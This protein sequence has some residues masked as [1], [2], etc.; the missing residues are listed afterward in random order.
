MYMCVVRVRHVSPHG[1]DY[2]REHAVCVRTTLHEAVRACGAEPPVGATASLRMQRPMPEI[3]YTDDALPV[4][5]DPAAV[6][7][8]LVGL[9]GGLYVPAPYRATP[10]SLAAVDIPERLRR[11]G[12]HP[13]DVRGAMDGSVHTG[14]LEP[15]VRWTKLRQ[16]VAFRWPWH[17][18]RAVWTLQRRWRRQKEEDDWCVLQQ[19]FEPWTSSS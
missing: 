5:K 17:V 9:R 6:V 15:R 19:G 8:D 3:V 11:L 1:P 18:Q 12:V 14:E 16:P 2:V 7:V 13:H 4:C 10:E